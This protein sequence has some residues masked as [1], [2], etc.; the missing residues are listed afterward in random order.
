MQRYFIP[1][2]QLDASSCRVIGQDAHHISNVLRMQAGDCVLCSDGQGRTVQARIMTITKDEIQCDIVHEMQQQRELP[3]S[4]T[5]AQ[6]LPK[7][8]KLEW[9]LQKGT[10]L[11]AQQFIPFISHRTIVKYD[12]KK[13]AKKQERWRKIIKEAAEQ[14]HRD[15]LPQLQAVMPLKELLEVQ[16]DHKLVAYEDLSIQERSSA[17]YEG[18]K[19]IK[20]KESMIIAIG[21]EGGFEEQEIQQLKEAGYQPVSLGKRIL[22]TETASQY[23][24]AAIS[25]YF[26]QM[27]G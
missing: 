27:G 5:I 23:V 4:V 12:H 2:E 22:R 11:G 7:G 24:L 13:E 8:D 20:P 21:P 6:G 3:I 15:V 1:K 14:S 25:F 16:A 18:L 17:F 26:E 9:I 19:K 10:E